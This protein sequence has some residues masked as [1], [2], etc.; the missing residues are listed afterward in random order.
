MPQAR[1]SQ[2]QLAMAAGGRRR[3]LAGLGCLQ[4]EGVFRCSLVSRR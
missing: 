3:R 1:N 4:K 2:A